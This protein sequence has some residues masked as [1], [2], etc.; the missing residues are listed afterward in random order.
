MI[1]MRSKEQIEKE[2][3]EQKERIEFEKKLNENN[4]ELSFLYWQLS[5]LQEELKEVEK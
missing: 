4:G 1:L 2:I 5:Q 3:K